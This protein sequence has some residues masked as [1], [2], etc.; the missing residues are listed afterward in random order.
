M[1]DEEGVFAYVFIDAADP[2]KSV[3]RL[4]A[5][6]N[7]TE[8][9]VGGE[10]VARVRFATTVVGA[11]EGFAVVQGRELSD[12]DDLLQEEELWADQKSALVEVKKGHRPAK[13]DTCEMLAIVRI[14]TRH[15]KSEAVFG[16]LNK[17]VKGD[18]RYHGVSMVFGSFDIL[19][20]L[21]GPDLKT[22]NKLVMG[23]QTR[24][25]L[26]GIVSTETSLADCRKKQPAG[27][28]RASEVGPQ[29]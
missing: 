1:D 24:R 13:R 19:L 4:V 18:K 12:L 15:G 3:K 16:T 10:M 21:D 29:K 22:L 20:T 6:L 5:K 25:G 7:G 27:R 17:L 14:R 23:L 8:R 11:Y 9:E 28:G 26:E 2:G